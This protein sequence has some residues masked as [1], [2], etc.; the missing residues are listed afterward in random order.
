MLMH[1]LK[2]RTG[3]VSKWVEQCGS[4]AL[5]LFI[6]KKMIKFRIKTRHVEM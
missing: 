2:Q 1:R 3:R 5:F 4:E 6:D